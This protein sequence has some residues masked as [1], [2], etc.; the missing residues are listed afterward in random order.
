MDKPISKKANEWLPNR[1]CAHRGASKNYPENTAIAFEAAMRAGAGWIETDLQLLADNELVVYHD[2][3]L[4]RTAQGSAKIATLSW[5]DIA[6]L[7]IGSWKAA[8]FSD[9]RPMRCEDL[10]FWQEQDP[11]SPSVIWEIKC[12]PDPLVAEA[13]AE[14]MAKRLSAAPHHRCIVS[15]FDR[16]FLRFLRPALQ[17][18]PLA[19]IA[20]SLPEDATLF[21]REHG[22]EGIHLDGYLLDEVGSS[23]VLEAGLSLRC[24][25][26]NEIGEANR[27]IS[28]GA[29]MIMTD[30]PEMF[31]S[32]SSCHSEF[33]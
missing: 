25:T 16:D 30:C 3:T 19:L 15:S 9:Q 21:C 13:A 24:Y 7:D 6:G 23:A 28:L 26:V 18:T 8:R 12:P 14:E 32:N 22:I 1:I 4:G 20:E 31:L 11:R 27:L 17:S 33:S 5:Q 29:E 10:I 2:D